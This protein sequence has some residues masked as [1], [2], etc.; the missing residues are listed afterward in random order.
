[1]EAWPSW[2]RDGRNIVFVSWTDAG[3]GTIRTVAARGGAARDVTRTPG[4]YGS[5]R[6]SPDGRAIAF[7]Q[8]EGGYLTAAR[9]GGQ[10]GIYLVGADGTNQRRL[11]V[12]GNSPQWGAGNDRLFFIGSKDGKARLVSTDLSGGNERVHAT[13]DLVN[14]YSVSPDGRFAAFRQNYQA[15]VT[16][17]MP[18][19]QDVAV[20]PD[21]TAL[22]VVRVSDDGADFINWSANG[23]RIH[24]SLGPTLFS[25]EV[26]R[27]FPTAPAGEDAPKFVA[28]T[29]GTSLAMTVPADRPNGDVLLT[30]ARIVTMAGAD[31]GVIEQGD[32]LIRGDRIAAVGPT[33]TLNASARAKRIDMAGKTI[34]PGFI[35]GHAHGPQGENDLVPQQNWA[36]IANLALGTTTVH[37]PSASAR[38]I[39][40]A[41]EMQ[42]AGI[43]LGPRTFSTGEIIYGAKAARVYAEIDSYEDALDSVRRLKAQ[44][45]N[46]VKN[47]NQPRRDQRQMVTAAA[48]A[49]RMLVVPE[50]GSLYTMD[51]SLIQ[52]GNSTIEHNVPGEVFYKDVV[53]LWSQTKVDYNPTLVVAYGGL[54][55]DPYWRQHTEVWK[56]PI[57]ARHE[58]TAM[59]LANNVRRNMAPEEDYIDDEAAR[60][61]IKLARRG[62]DV[63]IGAHGQQA[64]L[65]AHW[66]IWSFAR[67]GATPLE[68]LQ[69]ATIMP[70]RI[71]GYERDIGSLEAG[72]LADLVVLDAN[73]L[74]NI[75]DTDKIH[76]V[77]LGGR[78]YDPLTM[79]EVA[80]GNRK[81]APYWWET[82]GNGDGAGARVTRGHSH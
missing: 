26:E 15:F 64:G 49:E 46:S 69:A 23:R 38:E 77:M 36:A 66:E 62:V 60:E 25:A 34:V 72:K 17:L 16:P 45:A 58:P 44:G 59:L 78:L 33:G 41:A 48:Q 61:A 63:S 31:G 68:A 8:R 19:T 54:A 42:R 18:G 76:R 9:G 13:G 43:I 79:N 82:E 35:D 74:E 37:D 70:A 1:M 28:P 80:T 20:A 57:L 11:K 67:G 14:D 40:P 27:L 4:H 53:D 75:R 6:F 21:S 5:P 10:P 71:Y 29:T 22:P 32:I 47:Y 2:S 24:W 65:A 3:L 51:I 7:E 73:P 39:F 81:R 55:G 50:G 30:G 56:H 12:D 52:D